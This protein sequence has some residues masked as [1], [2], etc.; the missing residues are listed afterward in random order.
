MIDIGDLVHRLG[1]RDPEGAV[2]RAELVAGD[3][4]GL[5]AVGLAVDAGGDEIAE[6]AAAQ[7]VADADEPLAVP[8]EKDGATAG[9]A[10]VLGEAELLVGG[11]VQLALQDAVRPDANG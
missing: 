6:P 4:D 5:V 9:L 2:D 11:Q 7:E 10:V 1:E 3:R 8:R